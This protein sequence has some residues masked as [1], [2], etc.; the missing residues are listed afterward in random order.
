MSVA[1]RNRILKKPSKKAYFYI[2]NIIQNT[3]CLF[4]L[5]TFMRVCIFVDTFYYYDYYAHT[6]I[7][8]AIR[9]WP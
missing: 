8:I 5:N 1:D 7:V 4:Q 6:N 9:P 3:T 2:H